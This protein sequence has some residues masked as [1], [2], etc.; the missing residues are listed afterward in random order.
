V[1]GYPAS[2]E[3]FGRS[4]AKALDRELLLQHQRMVERLTKRVDEGA[5][6]ALEC[7]LRAA[8]KS[9]RKASGLSFE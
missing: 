1:S 4:G 8:I 3:L 7:Y 9:L 6:A 2:D 5:L